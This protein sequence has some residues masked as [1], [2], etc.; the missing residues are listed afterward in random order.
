MKE[1]IRKAAEE[2]IILGVKYAVVLALFG[3]VFGWLVN[4][5]KQTRENAAR[6]DQAFRWTLSGIQAGKLP[7]DWTKANV[8]GAQP[9]PLPLP[10]PEK[11]K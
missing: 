8:L 9:T 11:A 3:A 4:D 2:G 5:Y 7:A 10:S 1:R 6:G